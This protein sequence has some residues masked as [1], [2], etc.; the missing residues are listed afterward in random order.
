MRH[1][2]QA[3]DG[4]LLGGL[5]YRGGLPALCR[6]IIIL[7]NRE[8]GGLNASAS[9]FGRNLPRNKGRAAKDVG[10]AH[11][12]AADVVSND[13]TRHGASVA[14]SWPYTARSVKHAGYLGEIAAHACWII[15][16]GSRCHDSSDSYMVGGGDGKGEMSGTTKTNLR[17]RL[18]ATLEDNSPGPWYAELCIR[19]RLRRNWI[20][21]STR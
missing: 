7:E 11:Q 15:R 2:L 20:N 18:P 19:N 17:A 8:D 6:G 10:G 12:K 3:K 21:V 9:G 16:S 14:P 13:Q 1:L 4:K 5:N